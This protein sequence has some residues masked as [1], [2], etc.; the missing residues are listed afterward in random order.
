MPEDGA[1][2]TQL[3]KKRNEANRKCSYNQFLNWD[4][5]IQ[6]FFSK[7]SLLVSKK[8]IR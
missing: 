1:R 8:L 5:G 2:K 7:I 4:G 6:K 3:Q